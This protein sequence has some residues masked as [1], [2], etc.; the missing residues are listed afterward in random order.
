HTARLDGIL[1]DA[2][3]RFILTAAGLR[4]KIPASF[5]RLVPHVL[6][7]DAIPVE[8]AASWHETGP[9]GDAIAF[10]QYT[11]GSTSQ[12]KGVCVTHR[13][14][15]ANELA[16]EAATGVT[17]DDV[18]VSW[19]PLYHDM[20]LMGGLLSPLFTGYSAVLMSPRNFLE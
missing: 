13:N 16:I 2:A 1:R 4:D 3:P 17:A 12:P 19:L 10:L 9:R 18:F 8:G 14:L 15:V 20:G 6:A 7:V 5:G 11:S